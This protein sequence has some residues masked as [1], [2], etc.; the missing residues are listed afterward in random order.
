MSM[1]KVIPSVKTN[2]PKS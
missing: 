2:L 1:L